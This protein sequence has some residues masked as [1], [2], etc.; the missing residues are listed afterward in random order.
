[1]ES[2]NTFGWLHISDFHAGMN[3]S[4]NKWEQIRTKF[5]Q[6]ISRHIER[7]GNIDL[8][9]FSG[10]LTQKGTN[11]E[12]AAVLSELKILWGKFRD[13]SQNPALFLVPGNHDLTRPKAG[14]PILLAIAQWG[15]DGIE[16]QLMNTPDS[17]YLQ[18][19]QKCFSGYS[20][21]IEEIKKTDIPLA[22][23]HQGTL[24]GEGS[25]ILKVGDY[26][27]GVVGI[28][29][30]WS[31]LQGGNLKPKIHVS[32]E[33]IHH[34]V[35]SSLEGWI[36]SNH[37]NLLVTHHPESWFTDES[38]ATFRNEI[39][40]LGRFSAHL[41]GHMHE[42]INKLE[43]FGQG[44]SKLSLQ[45]A[46]LFGLEKYAQNRYD[47][48][49]G[50]YYARLNFDEHQLRVWPKR[51]ETINGAGGWSMRPETA[52]LPEDEHES[53]VVPMEVKNQKKK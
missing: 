5:H 24:P 11:E 20:K 27:V 10:D 4:N 34:S 19:L 49:H 45:A 16:E 15:Q 29:T 50:Y 1:M 40:P 30:A 28:N 44:K 7:H 21:L 14:S 12:Y 8:V 37:I 41:F 9:V 3:G 6:D 33:Q 2:P 52:S 31:H 38:A 47:R 17:F 32:E 35:P 53:A 43:D 51:A 26:K 39:N 22:L 42:S 18:D 48:R 23:D 13:L 36:A 25:A 46:S